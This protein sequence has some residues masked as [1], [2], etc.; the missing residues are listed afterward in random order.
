MSH[1][2]AKADVCHLLFL[3]KQT[4]LQ[5][6]MRTAADSDFH[7]AGLSQSRAISMGHLV[8]PLCGT[9]KAGPE[10]LDE[11]T[12]SLRDGLW[13][14]DVFLLCIPKCTLLGDHFFPSLEPPH[15]K[16]TPTDIHTC[17]TILYPK[18]SSR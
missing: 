18:A 9:E 4:C 15:A 5:L 2:R 13:F 17:P 10:R 12:W 8:R 16:Y 1:F 6:R 11:I 3:T 14:W 7:G